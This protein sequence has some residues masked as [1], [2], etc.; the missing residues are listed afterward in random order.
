M[1]EA[2]L[3]ATVFGAVTVCLFG[4]LAVAYKNAPDVSSSDNL[5]IVDSSA[6]ATTFAAT[7][8]SAKTTTAI[9]TTSTTTRKKAVTTTTANYDIE[10]TTTAELVTEAAT[11]ADEVATEATEADETLIASV[12]YNAY[13]SLDIDEAAEP[14][15]EAPTEAP[16]YVCDEQVCEPQTDP[17][18]ENPEPETPAEE[19]NDADAE[20]VSDDSL[21]ISES[22][23]ILLCNVVAHEAGS[24]W[25]SEFNKA[26]VVEVIMNR[27][28]SPLF[29][30]SISDVLTQPYQFTGS[31][32]YAFLGTYSGYVTEQ[33]KNAVKLYF[34][35]PSQFSQGYLYFWGDGCQ[36][37]FS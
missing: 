36:N 16:V 9:I 27:V 32:S 18:A 1:R 8:T 33:V 4:G 17:V 7:E 11:E 2:K 14:V 19:N 37:H 34:S 35:D 21:P 15:T 6:E 30:N 26:C 13:A 20:T 22:D 10:Y 25:I 5:E 31:E 28:Y 29:P 23:F 3:A 24:Y 12:D